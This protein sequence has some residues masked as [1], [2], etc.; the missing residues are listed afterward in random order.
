MF[1]YDLAVYLRR[2]GECLGRF[3]EAITAM[4]MSSAQK[5]NPM[6]YTPFESEFEA[7][8]SGKQVREEKKKIMAHSH[9]TQAPQAPV[10]PRSKKENEQKRK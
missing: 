1:F 4:I 7:E 9:P 2:P 8:R 6:I 5:G 10:H 3:F